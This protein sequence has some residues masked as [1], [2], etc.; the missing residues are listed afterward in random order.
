ML[1]YRFE[2]EAEEDLRDAARWYETEQ[3]GLGQ[4]FLQR[5]LEAAT[6]L[7]NFPD[8]G[9]PAPHLPKSLGI[10]RHRVQRFPYWLVYLI[11]EDVLVFLAVAHQRRR[12][13]YWHERLR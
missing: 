3:P 12:P 7:R 10:R 9:S 6:F 5:A 1:R 11:V 8:A 13:G 2:P 4:A